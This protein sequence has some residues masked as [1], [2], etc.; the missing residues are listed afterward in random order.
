[1]VA[2]EVGEECAVEIES[3]D[4]LLSNGVATDFH[5]GV[6]T[7]GIHHATEQAVEFKCVWRC[8]R[9]GNRLFVHI[10]DYGRK[11]ARLIA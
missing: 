9:G 7:T 10:I 2:R 3:R 8:V 11:Q 4:A 5:E 6:R 1:M